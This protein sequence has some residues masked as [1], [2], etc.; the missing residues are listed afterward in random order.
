[1]IEKRQQ[2]QQEIDIF[3]NRDLQSKAVEQSNQK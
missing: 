2:Q 1:L 3:N